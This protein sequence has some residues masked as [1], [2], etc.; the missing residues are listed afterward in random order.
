MRYF[1]FNS[2]ISSYFSHSALFSQLNKSGASSYLVQTP[3]SLELRGRPPHLSLWLSHVWLQHR[4]RLPHGRQD[5][6][7]LVRAQQGP[8]R[9]AFRHHRQQ[10]SPQVSRKYRN[11]W[12]RQLEHNPL[13]LMCIYHILTHGHWVHQVPQRLHDPQRDS[14]L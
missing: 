5:E 11:D 3:P 13:A 4:E 8:R 2:P 9:R 10:Q 12:I 6:V 1:N 7:P 14:L